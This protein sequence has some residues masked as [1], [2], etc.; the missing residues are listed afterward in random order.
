MIGKKMGIEQLDI[1]TELQY[2]NLKHILTMVSDSLTS[3]FIQVRN[4]TCSW[5]KSILLNKLFY[6]KL[7]IYIN[8]NM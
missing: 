6:L 1:L 3:E 5:N 2:R 4:K 8:I 7:Y